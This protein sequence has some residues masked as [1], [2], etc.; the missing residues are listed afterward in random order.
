[1]P[2]NLPPAHLPLVLGMAFFVAAALYAAVGHGGASAYL[3]VMGLVG[4]TPAEMKPIAL[5]LNIG[6]SLLAWIAFTRAGHFRPRLFW[7]VAVTSVPAA[8]LGG[9][10]RLSDPIFKLILAAALMVGAWRLVGGCKADDFTPRDPA[11]PALL[12]VGLVIG[13]LSGLIGIGGGIFL[14]P[15]LVLWR[16]SPAK[17]AAAV[18]AAFILVNSLAGL[19]G[20]LST[21]RAIPALAWVMLPA[22]LAGGW[23][24][25]YW[26]SR[27]AGSPALLRVLAAVLV[28]AAAKF[29][30][31]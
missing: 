8:L 25:S 19:A 13:F 28:M 9:W 7:P 27:R 23:L 31:N 11:R 12:L 24:G 22:V 4:M 10:L 20:F 18:S 26:G 14:T 21:G 2:A 16:W 3:A 6:V 15:L 30:I 5:T 17:S 1:M 29:V